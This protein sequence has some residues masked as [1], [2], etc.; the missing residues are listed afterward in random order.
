MSHRSSS[1]FL[2]EHLSLWRYNTLK[3][4]PRAICNRVREAHSHLH[5]L[6]GRCNAGSCPMDVDRRIHSNFIDELSTEVDS[7]SGLRRSRTEHRPPTMQLLDRP[8]SRTRLHRVRGTAGFELN[9]RTWGILPLAPPR[10]SPS[11]F[12]SCCDLLHH[13]LHHRCRPIHQP[14]F[15]T[16]SR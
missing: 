16:S 4:V 5:N 13:A 6:E 15:V 8:A 7:T 12:D 10:L 2:P 9:L 3:R 11:P 1:R 14:F